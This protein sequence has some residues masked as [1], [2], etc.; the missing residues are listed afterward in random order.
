[1]IGLPSEA[2]VW[3]ARGATDMRRGFDGL[4]RRFGAALFGIRLSGYR[5]AA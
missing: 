3:L 1:M 2:R 5:R 4:L